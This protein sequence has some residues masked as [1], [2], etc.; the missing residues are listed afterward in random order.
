[1][2]IA[3]A[4]QSHVAFFFPHVQDRMFLTPPPPPFFF[5]K[6]VTVYCNS[7]PL[8]SLIEQNGVLGTVGRMI[9]MGIINDFPL[10]CSH[11]HSFHVAATCPF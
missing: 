6:A 5:F 9:M 2:G 8:G 4:A 1:M 11:D 3:R 10:H 7:K